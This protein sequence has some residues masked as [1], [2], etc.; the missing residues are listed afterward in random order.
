MQ[1]MSQ[2]YQTN[3]D[4]ERLENSWLR[5]D[6]SQLSWNSSYYDD[7]HPIYFDNPYWVRNKSFEDDQRD[8]FFGYVLASYEFMDGLSLIARFSGDI[9]TTQQ[10]ERIAV[11]SVDPSYYSNLNA[12]GRYGTG[13]DGLN[14]SSS[15]AI[16]DMGARSPDAPTEP[17]LQTKGVTPLFSISIKVS[18]ISGRIPELP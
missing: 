14:P 7:L 6:G 5:A 1:S 18:V 16:W 11:G 2:W 12:Y 9:Y 3:V 17:F 4:Q 15:N 13:Y 10:N 8:R